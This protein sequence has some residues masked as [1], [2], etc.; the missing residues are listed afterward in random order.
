MNCMTI[1]RQ[2]AGQTTGGEFTAHNRADATTGLGKGT[3]GIVGY[4][5]RADNLT[6]ENLIEQMVRAGELSPAARDMNV[7][8]ALDQ[9]AG[10]NAIDRE[11]EYSF[12]SDDFPKVIFES[13]VTVTDND[14]LGREYWSFPGFDD[15]PRTDND[16]LDQFAQTLELPTVETDALWE[17]TDYSLS[18]SH[19]FA[20]VAANAI[21]LGIDLDSLGYPLPTQQ[22]GPKTA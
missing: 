20:V 4:T 21:R 17:G 14:W 7:E 11:D 9:H 8:E 12:D 1:T 5:Y 2:P 16:A 15:E 18:A 10:A 19:N 3:T 13:Q 6:P 22:N